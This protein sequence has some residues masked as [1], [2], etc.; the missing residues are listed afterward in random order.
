[1]R[2]DLGA[3]ESPSQQRQSC[4]PPWRCVLSTATQV[5]HLRPTCRRRRHR[6]RIPAPPVSIHGSS[7]RHLRCLIPVEGSI[8][9]PWVFFSYSSVNL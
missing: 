1:M 6:A 3:S 8:L 4:S 5:L 9:E 7:G 2:I